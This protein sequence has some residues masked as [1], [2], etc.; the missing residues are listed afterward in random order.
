M[1]KSELIARLAKEYPHLTPRD[2]ERAVSVI[3]ERITSTLAEG[4]RVEVRGFGSFSVKH[5]PARLSCNPRTGAPVEVEAKMAVAFRS[6][7]ALRQRLNATTTRDDQDGYP[8][9]Q[10]VLNEWE[11]RRATT[12]R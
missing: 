12:L 3:L 9:T 6:G 5:R 8:Q 2:V 11:R 7:L 1:I 10:S 4:G